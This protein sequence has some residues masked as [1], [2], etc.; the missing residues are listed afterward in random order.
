MKR[1]FLALIILVYSACL[2]AEETKILS[3]KLDATIN[4]GT[5]D[6][7]IS[8]VKRA[9]AEKYKAI[10]IHLNTPGGLLPST[11]SIV[12]SFLDSPVPVLVYVSPSGGGA[13]SA[14]VFIT[15]A[16]NFASMAPGTNIGA[17][18]PVS[19]GGQDIDGDMRLKVE[20]FA[21]S[22]IKAIAEQRGRN[23]AWAEKA[24]KESVALTD[25]EA[26]KE[27]VVDFTSS[28]VLDFLNSAK[29]KKIKVKG[30]EVEFPDLT[31]AR[32]D[33]Q[34]MSFRQEVV[35]I[36]SDPSIA[37]LLGVGAFGGIVAEFYHPGLIIPGTI[38][39]LCLI[40]TLVASQTIPINTGGVLLLGFGGLL[41]V[42]EMFV[43]SFGVLGIVGLICLVIGS[44]YVVDTSMIWAVDG[45]GLDTEI[46]AGAA[47]MVGLALL[48]LIY[49]ASCTFKKTAVTGKEGLMGRTADVKTDFILD[50]QRGVLRGKIFV[51]GELWDAE[52][53]PA[54]KTPKKGTQVKVLRLEGMILVVE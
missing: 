23:V 6:Y 17:A 24:V 30:V 43:P 20:N 34:E 3:L 35:S 53:K 13:I 31:L 2:C 29:G 25:T 33:V 42:A 52:M 41:M 38:G 22:L 19:G 4:P 11:Q 50:E 26:V 47:L 7:V 49:L 36:V 28:S 45:Y 32:I 9:E 21:A 44:V 1:I 5:A 15:L 27:K 54:E 10:I 40:L 16:G 51:N 39:V 37:S 14:G 8:G 46:V 18:H 12:E 48:F